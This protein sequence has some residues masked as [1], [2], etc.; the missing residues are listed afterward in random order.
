MRGKDQ[1][2]LMLSMGWIG[3]DYYFAA[4]TKYLF[5]EDFN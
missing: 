3:W 4:V 5:G 2:I 1:C